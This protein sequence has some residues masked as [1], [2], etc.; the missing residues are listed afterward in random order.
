MRDDGQPVAEID[1]QP[2][3][4]YVL[5][6]VVRKTPQLRGNFSVELPSIVLEVKTGLHAEEKSAVEE[7]QG[8]RQFINDLLPVDVRLVF[9]P[10]TEKIYPFIAS[11]SDTNSRA[12]ALIAEWGK[13]AE[14][15]QR[16]Y[17]SAISSLQIND[18][19]VFR[20]CRVDEECLEIARRVFNVFGENF[21]E[22]MSLNSARKDF[23]GKTRMENYLE[24]MSA[25]KGGQ[26]EK[27]GYGRQEIVI[28]P[29]FP[30]VEAMKKYLCAHSDVADFAL[31]EC[32]NEHAGTVKIKRGDFYAVETRIFDSVDTSEEMLA[33]AKYNSQLLSKIIR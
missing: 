10:V 33:R 23:Q 28:P 19:R 21:V 14:G 22:L 17:A 27:R 26:F 20:D 25:V 16:L 12:Q 8:L 4:E 15:Q 30:D 1:K 29:Y 5:E 2:T 32:K 31:A 11:T 18:S 24:L 3:T 13:T 6:K 9:A 7:A